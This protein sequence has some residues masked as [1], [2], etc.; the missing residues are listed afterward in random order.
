MIAA[1]DEEGAVAV[2]SGNGRPLSARMSDRPGGALSGV[3]PRSFSRVRAGQRPRVASYREVEDSDD[4]NMHLQEGR[5]SSSR[6][7]DGDDSYGIRENG[8]GSLLGI[9]RSARVTNNERGDFTASRNGGGGLK[10]SARG[11]L[12]GGSRGLGSP[13]T[14]AVD[15]QR[16]STALG[17]SH[18]SIGTKLHALDD[19]R[20]DDSR[21]A[22]PD[23][24][25]GVDL[26]NS[27]NSRGF[28]VGRIVGA[29]RRS[30]G[31]GPVRSSTRGAASGF[32]SPTDSRDSGGAMGPA[33]AGGGFNPPTRRASTNSL[34]MMEH[35]HGTNDQFDN[36]QDR[37]DHESVLTMGTPISRGVSR[38][39][40]TRAVVESSSSRHAAGGP[41]SRSRGGGGFA[42]RGR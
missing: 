20:H 16:R 3:R 19:S 25:N 12:N 10:G 23:P 8:S 2:L 31:S 41:S 11:F 36:V 35:S 1:D 24:V 5:T 40:S 22:S 18:H 21:H 26:A 39:K 6:D 27:G 42:R 14:S 4:E 28:G 30:A 9:G 13:G 7:H 15:T 37:M 29:T 32:D 17:H 38:A 34:G 33:G